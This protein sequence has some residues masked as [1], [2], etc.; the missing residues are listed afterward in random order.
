MAF[1]SGKAAHQ[2]CGV[3]AP[4]FMRLFLARQK[5]AETLAFGHEFGQK[6]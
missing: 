6:F 1:S 4:P 3:D 2:I 5:W